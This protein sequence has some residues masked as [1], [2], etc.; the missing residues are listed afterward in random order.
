MNIKAISLV[1]GLSITGNLAAAERMC[2]GQVPVET[3]TDLVAKITIGES[4]YFKRLKCS[5]YFSYYEKNVNFTQA[6]CEAIKD[7][8]F[9][10]K[11]YAPYGVFLRGTDS[12][13]KDNIASYDWAIKNSV[14]N[15]VLTTYNAFNAAYVFEQAGE[16]SAT[17]TITDK[18][19]TTSTDTK[20]ITV[21]ARDG[22]DYFVDSAIGDDRYDGLSQTPDTTC[23]ANIAPLNSCTGPWKTATRALGEMSPYQVTNYPNGEYTAENICSSTETVDI[24]RYPQ[25]NFKLFRSSTFVESEALKDIDGE[26]LPVVPTQ[27]CSDT[28]AKRDTILRPGDQVLFNRGQQF[29]LET[30]VNTTYKY[31]AT[32]DDIIYYYEKL[33]TQPIVVVGHWSQAKGVHFGAYGSGTSPA[34]NNTG[35]TSN[36]ALHF[37][38]VGMLGF[39]MSNL[40]FNLNSNTPNP[41]E[42]RATFVTMNGNPTS[43]V[44]NNINIKGMNQGIIASVDES[45]HGLFIFNST[46]YDSK[47][48]QLYTSN[49]YNDVAVV[50]NSFDYSY[51]HLLYTSISHGLIH[52]NTLSRPAFG[53]TAFR[54]SGE[55]FTNPNNYVWISD[56][57]ISGWID[58]RTFAEFGP[59]L[60]DGK[61]YNYSLINISPNAPAEKAIHDV[62][63]TRN[64]VTDAENIMNIGVGENIS[65]HHNTFQTADTSSTNRIQLSPIFALRPLRNISID[66]NK[67]IDSAIAEG[68]YTSSFISLP[69]YSGTKCSD[70]FTHQ[71]INI[72]NNAFYSADNQKRMFLFTPLS[73]GKD[74][75]GNSLPDLSLEQAETFLKKELILTN[76]NFITPDIATPSI[77]IGG[78]SRAYD[79]LNETNI[80][81]TNYFQGTESDLGDYRLYNQQSLFSQQIGSNTFSLT[82]SISIATFLASEN[83][84]VAVELTWDDLI[85]YAVENNIK[86]AEIEVMILN[87]VLASNPSSAIGVNYSSDVGVFEQIGQWFSSIPDLFKSNEDQWSD[88]EQLA[89]RYEIQNTSIMKSMTKK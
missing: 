39:S 58:P 10:D 14:T 45:T 86:P 85:A 47:V 56:N 33:D 51:N 18:N 44:F 31:T 46:F 64:T 6:E 20:N 63:F 69:N 60:G 78:A 84:I 11:G 55:N 87:Q 8:L 30:G 36:T 88:A 68:P 74:L 89:I 77:Q 41:F 3:S 67:F 23:D 17:L 25:G 75:L 38:G 1:L 73:Q 70:Q 9:A 50:N 19:G 76:N 71:K 66:N 61:R 65:I 37:Q 21:W 80:D 4:D 15:E 83:T 12:T 53:R 13:G 35:K 62:V 24:R 27:L 82:D 52:N 49:S 81:W 5:H 43:T 54:L 29:K 42:T 57:K 79:N 22:K 32:G 48:T 34:I 40:D 2:F 7:Q 26:Y 72:T 16:Y 28:V 59:G